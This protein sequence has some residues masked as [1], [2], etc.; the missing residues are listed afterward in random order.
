MGVSDAMAY[1]NALPSIRQIP[2]PPFPTE[3]LQALEMFFDNA[4]YSNFLFVHCTHRI[5]VVIRGW[6]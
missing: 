5:G 6:R 2:L 4:H 1:E 3:P